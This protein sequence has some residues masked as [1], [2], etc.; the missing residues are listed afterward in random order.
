[1]EGGCHWQAPGSKI[2]GKFF[3]GLT[4]IFLIFVDEWC[5]VP[6]ESAEKLGCRLNSPPNLTQLMCVTAH[7]N[8]QIPLTQFANLKSKENCKKRGVQICKK[9]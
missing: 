8:Q 4:R 9:I 3:G 7:L 2:P 5:K 6:G 1:M